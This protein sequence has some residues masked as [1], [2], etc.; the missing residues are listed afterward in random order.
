MC[1]DNGVDC[2]VITGSDHA[3]NII[4]VGSV[5]YNADSTFDSNYRNDPTKWNYFLKNMASFND[6]DHDRDSKFTS[7][8]FVSRY[9]M[10]ETDYSAET[11]QNTEDEESIFMYR[12]YNPNSGEHFY[13]GSTDERD[14]LV[15]VGWNYEGPG[16]IAPKN[17][18][19]SVFRLYNQN[20]GDHHYTNSDEER[21]DLVAAG[22]QYEGIA[23]NSASPDNKPLYRLY[24]PNAQSGSHHYTMSEEER[25]NL[26][27][28]GWKYEGVG[29]F[30]L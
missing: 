29:W 7:D 11:A 30:G 24:N 1:L 14:N 2:R 16:W 26:V 15:N 23:W 8:E 25:D 3:W 12:L 21:D 13:T 4:N 27:S 10:S 19:D 6:G 28:I 9:L 18:G 20:A 22:W 5:Y 17:T